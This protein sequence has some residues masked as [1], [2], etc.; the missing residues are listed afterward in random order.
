MVPAPYSPPPSGAYGVQLPSEG[1]GHAVWHAHAGIA[2][3]R[4]AARPGGGVAGF[5][6]RGLARDCGARAVPGV[7]RGRKRH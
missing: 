6:G 3:E 2:A 5:G 7:F 1:M 4:G